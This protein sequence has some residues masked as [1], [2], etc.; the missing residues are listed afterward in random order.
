MASLIASPSTRSF[1]LINESY[2][3]NLCACLLN[4]SGSGR[5]ALGFAGALVEI[6]D[7]RKAISS[8]WRCTSFRSS[9]IALLICS[10][11]KRVEEGEEEKKGRISV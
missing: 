6:I 1:A 3:L 10:I 7:R 5:E 2:V 8:R 9:V 4:F 11:V